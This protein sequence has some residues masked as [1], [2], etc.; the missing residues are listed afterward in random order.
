MRRKPMTGTTNLA[1]HNPVRDGDK[2]N[3]VIEAKPIDAPN[4]VVDLVNFWNSKGLKRVSGNTTKT[5]KYTVK[6]LTGIRNGT[7]ITKEKYSKE[8][9][10]LSIGRFS[11]AAL[12]KS[13]KPEPGGYKNYLSNLSLGE[14]LHNPY[15]KNDTSKSYC[16]YYIKNEPELLVMSEDSLTEDEADIYK[17]LVCIYNF[18]AN[19]GITQNMSILESISED[20]EYFDLDLSSQD[21]DTFIK[22]AIKINKIVDNNNLNSGLYN[23]IVLITLSLL[24]NNVKIRPSSYLM[25]YTYEVCLPKLLQNMGFSSA[26]KTLTRH[27]K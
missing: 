20:E 2:S 14:F 8:D 4:Y 16:I 24:E 11:K 10:Q 7:L 26:G 5:Y 27:V 18:I 25:D 17:K 9:I 12:N 19:C 22:S 1:F 13:Y 15:G 21:K 6:K 23:P 3:L